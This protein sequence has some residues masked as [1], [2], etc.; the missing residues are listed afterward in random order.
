MHETKVEESHYRSAN[1]FEYE[2]T[3]VVYD[4]DEQGRPLRVSKIEK[5]K[6]FE[7]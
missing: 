5:T 4:V 2:E 6:K 3:K 1:G 7:E